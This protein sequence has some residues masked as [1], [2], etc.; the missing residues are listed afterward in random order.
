VG[1]KAGLETVMKRKIP[2]PC[3]DSNPRSSSPWPSAIIQSYPGSMI[4]YKSELLKKKHLYR[5][6]AK[7][8]RP[9]LNKGV[10]DA[11]LI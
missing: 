4:N 9:N 3:R 11:D 5:S 7:I 6:T 8:N 1:P 2:S 10:A